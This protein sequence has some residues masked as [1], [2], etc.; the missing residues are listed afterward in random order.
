MKNFLILN[1]FFFLFSFSVFS[2]EA[3]EKMKN[4]ISKVIVEA[5]CGRCCFKSKGMKKCALSVKI[6]GQVYNV[7]GRDIKDFGKPRAKHG[8]C[9]AIRKAEVSGEIVN[10]NFMAYDFK[11]LPLD[12]SEMPLIEENQSPPIENKM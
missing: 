6:D 11:L 4:K 7:E 1:S 3:S 5:G 8:L 2:Q 10:N 9:R 12:K